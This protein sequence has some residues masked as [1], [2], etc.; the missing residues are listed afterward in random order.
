MNFEYN[1]EVFDALIKFENG[2]LYFKYSDNCGVLSNA[3]VTINSQT[4][5]F[6]NNDLNFTGKTEE[7]ND[8][9]EQIKNLNAIDSSGAM[10]DEDFLTV[11]YEDDLADELMEEWDGEDE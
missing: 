8:K 6:S 4:Y 1:F 9:L 5:L 10:S 11:H 3:E 7:L 2:S